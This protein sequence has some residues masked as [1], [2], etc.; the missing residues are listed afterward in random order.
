M[1]PTTPTTEPTITSCRIVVSAD[2]FG[3]SAEIN[4]AIVTA[5]ERDLI[6]NTSIM[7]NMAGFEDACA[8]TERLRL[9]GRVGTHLN[10]SEG[11]PLTDTM[12]GIVRFC[13]SDGMR[14]R[15]KPI[16]WLGSEER[17]AVEHE[18][19]AQVRACLRRGLR[20]AHLNSH[21]HFHAEWPVGAIVARLAKRYGIESV[22]ITRN[23]GPGM[24]VA[25]RLYKAAYNRRLRKFGLSTVD[26]FGSVDHVLPLLPGLAGTC[27]VSVHPGFDAHG[28][29]IDRLSGENLEALINR[30]R[31]A[32]PTES[33]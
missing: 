20:P 12:R 3:M 2:D 30:V 23:C 25:R 9:H 15:T 8:L 17:A 26:Y 24:G 10:L 13:G 1:T 21:H 29:L 16:L 31:G 28:V 19:E 7:A 11:C 33:R 18:L 32:L 5:F 22:R 6:S 4:R 14:R 27:E